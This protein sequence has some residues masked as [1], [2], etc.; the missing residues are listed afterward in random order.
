MVCVE[1]QLMLLQMNDQS[2][3]IRCINNNEMEIEGT[4][5][6]RML[7]THY[8]NKKLWQN[9]DFPKL[10]ATSAFH[11]QVFKRSQDCGWYNI[12]CIR[13]NLDEMMNNT[14]LLELQQNITTNDYQLKL[15]SETYQNM[16]YL[17]DQFYKKIVEPLH[18]QHLLKITKYFQVST[19]EMHEQQPLFFIQ[20]LCF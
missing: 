4:I 19:Q 10:E 11:D 20:P 16:N 9:D 2:Y 18:R 14:L 12:M 17:F 5:R 13:S 8:Q 1:S 6:I 3:A 7:I 15:L